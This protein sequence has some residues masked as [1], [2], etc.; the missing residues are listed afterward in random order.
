M[1]WLEW[2][3]SCS[4]ACT[5]A[6]MHTNAL[7]F[8]GFMGVPLYPFCLSRH[9]VTK[10]LLSVPFYYTSVNC[11]LY[12]H[13]LS[14]TMQVYMWMCACQIICLLCCKR[15]LH[16]INFPQFSLTSTFDCRGLQW[17]ISGC[18]N[19]L[20]LHLS[21]IYSLLITDV[22]YII[23]VVLRL[24]VILIPVFSFYKYKFIVTGTVWLWI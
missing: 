4:N 6:C 11:R 10:T 21:S 9:V 1:E 13:A 8:Y 15:E 24:E 20:K 23:W 22:E 3:N 18:G 17:N 14:S 12:V 7:S 2:M 5:N 16:S 19:R